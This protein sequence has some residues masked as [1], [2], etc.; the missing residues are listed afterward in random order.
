[1]PNKFDPN[2]VGVF[3]RGSLNRSKANIAV[4]CSFPPAWRLL[5]DITTHLQA[6]YAERWGYHYFTDESERYEV[7]MDGRSF[8][9]RGFAK[10]D[11]IFHFMR[12]TPKMNGGVPYEWLVW[13]DADLVI[14]NRG[15]RLESFIAEAEGKDLILGYDANGHHSTIFMV[16]NCSRGRDFIWACNNAGRSLFIAHPWHEM[17][18]MRYFLQTP[19]YDNMAH[20]VSAKR[21]CA[22]LNN[23]YPGVPADIRLDYNWEP[24][25]FALHLSA[26][27]LERRIILAQHYADPSYHKIEPPKGYQ[28]Q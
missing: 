12:H 5:S 10:F 17:E 11:L 28:L 2:D 1:M 4:V 22:I 6:E 16:R 3:A 25:D 20:Y 21:L 19:P 13:M 27:S 24:G 9:I 26:L 7:M 18:A 8:P 14:T 23:E 15:I